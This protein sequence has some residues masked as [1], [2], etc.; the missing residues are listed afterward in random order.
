MAQ[1]ASGRYANGQALRRAVDEAGGVLSVT[2]DDL[3][4]AHG[5]YGKLGPHVRD[6]IRR[7]LAGH[8]LAVLP[9]LR[10]YG[11][12]EVA[13]YRLDSPLQALVEAIADPTGANLE[14]LRNIAAPEGENSAVEVLEKIRALVLD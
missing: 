10:R 2:M 3:R 8:G 6:Q 4:R 7:W 1:N 14:R 11:E 13:V 9:E 5:V 12:E